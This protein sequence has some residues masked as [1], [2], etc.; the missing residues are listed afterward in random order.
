MPKIIR[1]RSD[2]D[3]AIEISQINARL[4]ELREEE[5]QLKARREFLVSKLKRKYKAFHFRDAYSRLFELILSSR[6]REQVDLDL[7]RIRYERL[8]EDVPMKK[9]KWVEVNVSE[10]QEGF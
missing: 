6:S 2:V 9:V 8:E 3:R 7:V 10:V 5:R 4:D 1:L